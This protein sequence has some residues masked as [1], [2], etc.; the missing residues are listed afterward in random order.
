MF[1][2]K[3]LARVKGIVEILLGSPNHSEKPTTDSDLHIGLDLLKALVVPEDIYIVCDNDR[4]GQDFCNTVGKSFNW[5]NRPGLFAN[6]KSSDHVFVLHTGGRTER[7]KEIYGEL[8]SALRKCSSYRE[9][10]LW[11]IWRWH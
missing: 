4:V 3:N 2:N 7:Q 1:E 5:L 10:N 6:L 8:S 9:L 11:H